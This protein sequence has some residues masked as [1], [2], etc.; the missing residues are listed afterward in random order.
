MGHPPRFM[1]ANTRRAFGGSLH[2]QP[3]KICIN[4]ASYEFRDVSGKLNPRYERAGFQ[5]QCSASDQAQPLLR[6][7]P[8]TR[9]TLTSEFL[10][11]LRL[12]GIASRRII[13]KHIGWGR[14]PEIFV[15]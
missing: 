3:K 15:G 8:V 1:P 9:E 14:Y 12:L 11:S 4:P 6:A 2:D 10:G 13:A 5:R 7:L